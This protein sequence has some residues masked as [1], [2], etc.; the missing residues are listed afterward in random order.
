MAHEFKLTSYS[1]ANH[2]YYI[3]ITKSLN[4]FYFEIVQ[5]IIKY[6][7]KI[8]DMKVHGMKLATKNMKVQ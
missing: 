5:N 3:S 1:M 2:M 4:I 6:T 7:S 8:K